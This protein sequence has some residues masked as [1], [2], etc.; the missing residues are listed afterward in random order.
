MRYVLRGIVAL[1]TVIGALAL[2]I[3][4]GLGFTAS[5]FQPAPLPQKFMLTLNLDDGVTEVVRSNPL[6]LFQGNRPLALSELSTTL[7]RAAQDPK[8]AG[9]YT[10]LDGRGPSLAQAQE[11]HDS[12]VAFRRSGKRA[13]LYS[14]ELGE[15]GSGSVATYI[16][17]AF[18]DVWLQPSGDVGLAGFAIESPF[19][20]GTF[21]LFGIQP[22]FGGRYEYKT[23]ID[24]FTQ[25]KMT[26]PGKESYDL[27]LND[28]TSQVSAG[29][30][31][32]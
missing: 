11:I 4:V 7:D 28:W 15:F 21:D 6:D 26:G 3:I 27:L 16:A 19:V 2:I 31:S 25:S 12:V 23:A 14:T 24:M 18:D 32:A 5:R 20:K 17:S 1:L 13:T 8:V 10:R 30:V 29:C 9:L 22:Q